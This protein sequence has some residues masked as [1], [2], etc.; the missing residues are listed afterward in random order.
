MSLVWLDLM[1]ESCRIDNSH[2]PFRKVDIDMF[3]EESLS[4]HVVNFL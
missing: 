2:F 4:I 1:G 3:N